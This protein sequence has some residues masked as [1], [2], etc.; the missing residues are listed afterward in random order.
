[1][2]YLVKT[3]NGTLFIEMIYRDETETKKSE[4]EKSKYLIL[5]KLGEPWFTPEP[6]IKRLM[7]K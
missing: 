1:M 7:E 3:V 2:R 5:G 6:W 4:Q